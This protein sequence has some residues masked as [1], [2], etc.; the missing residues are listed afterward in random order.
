MNHTSKSDEGASMHTTKKRQDN[1][2]PVCSTCKTSCCKD[3][4]PPIT[5][6]RRKTIE[7]YLKNQKIRIENPFVQASYTFPKEDV[8]GY[9]IFY[10]RNKSKC[11]VH[12]VKPETCVAGPVTFDI[13][14]KSQKIEWHLK[15][16]KICPVAGALYR[17]KETLQAHVKSAK[18]E[19]LSLV[20]ELDSQALI[21]IL[22]IEEPE[23]FK[24]DEDTLE[25]DILDKLITDS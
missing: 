4:R 24:I 9:C 3:A 21:A 11:L 6:Q 20:R 1:F 13:N 12:P 23:T 18:K 15:M 22:K 17:K 7:A 2:F 5:P 16:E 8:E 25:K 10:D 14:T 19:I